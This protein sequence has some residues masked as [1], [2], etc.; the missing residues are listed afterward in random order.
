MI[1]VLAYVLVAILVAAT[2]LYLAWRAPL[3]PAVCGDPTKDLQ[4]TQFIR[5]VC[6]GPKSRA[7]HYTWGYLKQSVLRAARS[8]MLAARSSVT[9][10]MESGS[11]PPGNRAPDCKLSDLDGTPVNLSSLLTKLGAG[12]KPV[13]LNFGTWRSCHQ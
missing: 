1:Q 6:G 3:S 2:L 11:P 8:L 10:S 4:Y 5:E 7:S 12:S 13:V 9:G